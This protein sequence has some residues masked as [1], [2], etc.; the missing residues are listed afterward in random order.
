MPQ[1]R[2]IGCAALSRQ[3]F[4]AYGAPFRPSPEISEPPLVA[5]TMWSS[6]IQWLRGWM[7]IKNRPYWWPYAAAPVAEPA[8]AE[9]TRFLIA[10]FQSGSRHS[11]TRELSACEIDGFRHVVTENVRRKRFEDDVVSTRRPRKNLQLQKS[12]SKLRQVIARYERLMD[13]ASPAGGIRRQ[14]EADAARQVLG[15]DGT[16]GAVVAAG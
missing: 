1:I 9:N 3:R 13:G 14:E 5:A 10:I 4:L 8:C 7:D 15:R 11:T 6:R 16:G 2:H 12:L